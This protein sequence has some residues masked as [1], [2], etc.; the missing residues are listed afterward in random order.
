MDDLREAL[1]GALDE[2]VGATAKQREAEEKL[3]REMAA[4]RDAA[5]RSLASAW[6]SERSAVSARVERR[7]RELASAVS[8]SMRE[9]LSRDERMPVAINHLERYSALK[10][11]QD[12]NQLLARIEQTIDLAERAVGR[13]ASLDPQAAVSEAAATFREALWRVSTIA[14]AP[15][16]EGLEADGAPAQSEDRA[17][18]LASFEEDAGAAFDDALRLLGDFGDGAQSEEDRLSAFEESLRAA[19]E[20]AESAH[21]NRLKANAQTA[22]GKA[23]DLDDL[24]VFGGAVECV[25]L[26][27]P[28]KVADLIAAVRESFATYCRVVRDNGVFSAF[29]EGSSFGR[30]VGRLSW[31]SAWDDWAAEELG[32]DDSEYLGDAGGR[33]F[34]GSRIPTAV[35]DVEVDGDSLP[36]VISRMREFNRQKYYGML[37]DDFKQHVDAFWYGFG[38]L[39]EAV[40]GM[41]EIDLAKY[42]HY[43]D[44]L[45]GAVAARC[46]DL[47]VLMDDGQVD[48]YCKQIGSLRD[49]IRKHGTEWVVGNPERR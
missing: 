41:F 40:N 22:A 19:K 42:S 15:V 47:A 23:V 8:G 6:R 48:A 5:V 1:R 18:L 20:Q 31:Y 16:E 9:R 38:K 2:T 26:F 28:A 10:A 35:E 33:E 24:P 37:D 39:M 44:R 36:T 32:Y 29:S 34:V 17:S 46:G 3:K 7:V 30:C 49:E 4:K 45:A 43:A 25:C 14:V 27:E 13:S 12:R 11:I 21:R